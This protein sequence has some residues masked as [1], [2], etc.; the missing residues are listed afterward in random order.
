MP[1]PRPLEAQ[2]AALQGQFTKQLTALVRTASNAQLAQATTVAMARVAPPRPVGRSRPRSKAP[3]VP[4]LAPTKL[5]Q[6]DDAA[7]GAT[8]VARLLAAPG[9]SPAELTEFVR[10]RRVVVGRVLARL[11][12]EGLVT[13]AGAGGGR[14]YSAVPE[15]TS[16][17]VPE[18]ATG[19]AG[20]ASPRARRV[21]RADREAPMTSIGNREVDTSP[22]VL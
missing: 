5:Y 17:R 13:A 1:R 8:L 15:A 14:R 20:S 19:E 16:A 9:Q 2:I 4:A 22:P 18:P 6:V 11:R 12:R 3:Q 7:L 21:G 10:G